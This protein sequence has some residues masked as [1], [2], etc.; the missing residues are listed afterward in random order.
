MQ[1]LFTT[2]GP[3]IKLELIYDRAGRSEGTAFVYY[4]VEEDAHSAIREFDGANAKG[5][6]ITLTLVA[7]GGSGAPG[8]RGG[9]RDRSR[10]PDRGDRGG[11]SLFDRI[12]RGDAPAE[13]DPNR[14]PTRKATP[15]GID[16][17]VP[18]DRRR[19]RDSSERER[20]SPPANRSR[21]R[22]GGRGDRDR[23]GD[24]RGGDRGGRREK[25]S[26][27]N[28]RP[29][30]TV[31]ELDAEMNDYFAAAEQETAA[32]PAVAEAAPAVVAAADEDE[33]MIL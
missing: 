27:G 4:E 19:Q 11:R 7:R 32:A 16:R 24:R 26:G 17:Y 5:Q 6:P 28:P 14:D 21:E 33:E 31:E 13:R 1:D 30:K 20:R 29:K 3:V 10:S 2:Q 18:P 23:G 15:P 9:P 22:R 25:P 12:G 8:A